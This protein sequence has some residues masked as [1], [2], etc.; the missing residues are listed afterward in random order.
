VRR[1]VGARLSPRGVVAAAEE[2]AAGESLAGVTSDARTWVAGALA[3]SARTQEES[4]GSPGSHGAES[5][6]ADRHDESLGGSGL[7]WA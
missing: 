7:G 6:L 4:V 3:S 1:E 2:R 5:D